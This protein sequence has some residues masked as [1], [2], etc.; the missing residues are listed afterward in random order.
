ML[1]RILVIFSYQA[2]KERKYSLGEV[3]KEQVWVC[4]GQAATSQKVFLSPKG[5]PPLSIS[6]L[7]CRKL[8]GNTSSGAVFLKKGV[9]GICGVTIH[10]AGLL[11]AM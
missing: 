9:I 6:E 11:F 3:R 10:C 2:C 7:C 4:T 8:F 1:L 5:E